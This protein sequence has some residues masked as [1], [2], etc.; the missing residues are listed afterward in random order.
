[1]IVLVGLEQ[2]VRPISAR[3]CNGPEGCEARTVEEAISVLNPFH[4]YL[5]YRMYGQGHTYNLTTFA[6]LQHPD[7][8]VHIV[9]NSPSIAEACIMA[10]DLL[11]KRTAPVIRSAGPPSRFYKVST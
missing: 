8:F 11:V 9:V 2:G 10:C 7:G 3:S 6:M 1:M 5:R 4:T